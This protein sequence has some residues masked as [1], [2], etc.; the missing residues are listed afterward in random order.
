MAD[1]TDITSGLTITPDGYVTAPETVEKRVGKKQIDE[2]TSTLQEYKNG[3]ANLERRVV[4]DEQ[5]YKL[6]HWDVIRRHGRQGCDE[7]LKPRPTSAW[8]FNAILNKHADAMDNIPSPVVLP[9]EPSDEASA[10]TLSSILPTVMEL[11]DFEQTYSAAWWE[12]LKHGTSCYGVFWDSAAENGLGEIA[13]SEIDLL[14]VF[15]EPG[16][17]DIQRSRNLYIVELVDTDLLEQQYPEL[18]D[19]LGGNVIDLTQYVYDDTVD[20]SDKSLVVDWYYKRRTEDGRTLL[21]YCKF[22][23]DQV[24]YASENDPQYADRGYYDHGQYPVVMDTLFPEE[25]TPVGF[26]YVSI[27]KDPQ[28]YIDELYSNILDY[29]LKATHPRFFMAATTG[30]NEE[31][32]NDWTKPIVNVEGTL[33]DTRIRQIS[34]DPISS[35]YTNIIQMKIEEMQ[36]TVSNRDVNSGGAPGGGVTAASA[37]AALQEAGNKASRDMIAASYRVY[38]QIGKLCVELMRQFYDEF[39]AFRITGET[40]EQEF[41]Q[42]SAAQIREQPV[43]IGADGQMLYRRPVFDLKIVA[44]KKNPFS[45]MEQNE[46]AKELYSMGFFNPEMAQQSLNALEMMDFEGIEKVKDE[47]RQ[48]QTLLNICQQLSQQLEQAMGIIGQLTGGGQP[49]SAPAAFGAPTEGSAPAPAPVS[50]GKSEGINDEIMASQAPMTSY[51][52]RLA[53]RSTPSIEGA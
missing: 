18:K 44:Q 41:V 50:G 42:F 48:G 36:D 49:A 52:Q 20:T 1:I 8:L 22:V 40:G 19:K 47:V 34:L 17:T 53:K 35:I 32:Y 21:H 16:I 3:K 26:G 23:G 4:E 45:R 14:R 43:G 33:D 46:R 6:R 2:A 39:R 15:W 31:Q 10:K 13:I 38:S 51:G 24:L 29:A 30:V 12:K 25:G 11:C 5:W 9:R 28:I 37:I 27:C 7:A